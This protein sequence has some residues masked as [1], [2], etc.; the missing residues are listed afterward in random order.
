M[1]GLLLEV[2]LG[3]QR[4]AV[5][6]TRRPGRDGKTAGGAGEGIVPPHGLDEGAR[7]GVEAKKTNGEREQR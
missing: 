5:G 7:T 1:V 6:G 3:R 4:S 2:G